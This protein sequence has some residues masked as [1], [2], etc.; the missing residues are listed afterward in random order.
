MSY[1]NEESKESRAQQSQQDRAQ[2]DQQPKAAEAKPFTITEHI[3]LISRGS[4]GTFGMGMHKVASRVWAHEMPVLVSLHGQH[5][6]TIHSSEEVEFPTFDVGEEYLRMKRKYNR[7]D[8]RELVEKVY[9]YDHSRLATLLGVTKSSTAVDTG[10]I[11]AIQ[12]DHRT[13]PRIRAA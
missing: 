12:V 8:H 3:V 4:D 9:G 2:R 6:V 10:P 1:P 13:G 11:K 5:N 7:G